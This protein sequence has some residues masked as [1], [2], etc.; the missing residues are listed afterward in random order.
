MNNERPAGAGWRHDAGW[1]MLFAAWAVALSATL[2]AIFVGEIMGQTPCLLCWYQRIFMF[3]LAVILGVAA[4][5]ADGGAFYYGL[6]LAVP[7]GAFAAYHSLLYADIL[8]EAMRPCT[9]N[10]PSCT[11][12]AM[13]L[14]GLPLPYLSLMAFVAITVLLFF[15]RRTQ[16]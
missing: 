3:P 4:L 14:V 7:G 1:L 6:P 13:T 11:D 16:S 9:Q 10:G 2:G 12:A 5:R 15:S 8:T